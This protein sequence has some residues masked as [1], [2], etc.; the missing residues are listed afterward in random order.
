VI[1][2]STN[3]RSALR[4]RQRG[5]V[6]D[7]YRY[8]A[9]GGGGSARYWQYKG[10]TVAGTSM[11]LTDLQPHVSGASV[12][13][14]KATPSATTS[15]SA[16]TGSLSNLFDGALNTRCYW[17][18]TVAEAG[19]FY[20]RADLGSAKKIASVRLGGFDTTD[21]YPSAFSLQYSDDDSSWTTQA[22]VSGLSYPGNNTIS[23]FI[24]VRGGGAI[25]A[26]RYWRLTGITIGGSF[27]E[28]S[29]IELWEGDYSYVITAS[30]APSSGSLKTLGDGQLSTETSWADT[31]AEAGGFY[32][33]FDFGAGFSISVDGLK[34]GAGA[35]NNNF[36]STISVESSND[37]SSWTPRG[38]VA[39][40]TYPGA[41]TLTALLTPT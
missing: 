20:I 22:S 23:D 9:S 31:T 3:I 18:D 7:P 28:I 4:S 32:I 5:F 15:S 2:R 11:Q 16:P 36:T 30:N 1:L 33:R 14:A 21:R 25:T 12:V 34:L 17:T 39:G 19:G 26:H 38:S 6:L 24:D 10:F 41:S 8:A 13:G 37:A 29:E 27:L 35:N 40:I